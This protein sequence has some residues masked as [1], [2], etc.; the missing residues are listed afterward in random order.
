[1]RHG[2]GENVLVAGVGA[3]AYGAEAVQGG[4]AERGGEVSVGAAAG[5]GFTEGEMH[6]GGEGFGGVIECGAHAAFER[7]AG[8]AAEDLETRAALDGLESVEAAFEL[9]HV[10]GAD[11]AKIDY[12]AGAF[13]DDIGTGA[14]FDDVDV[15]GG[16]AAR[17][18][19]FYY[20]RD[21]AGEFVDGV[22]AFF[23]REAGVGGAAMHD[24]FGFADG[25]ARSFE[26]AARA[27]GGLENEDGI[28]AAGFGFDE[29]AGGVAADFLVGG[30][31][32]D[33][34]LAR[35]NI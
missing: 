25:F 5:G 20:A 23:R 29:F 18:G 22:D 33:E 1:M 28:T 26:Q 10:G 13:G 27:V 12:R 16:T 7:R 11:G 19:E 6:F 17:I 31:Q 35:K 8:E 15:D 21:L 30:P 24:D 32:K 3:V 2:S 9:T 4:N 34:A 14:A